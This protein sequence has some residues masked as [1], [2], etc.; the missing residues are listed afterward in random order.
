MSRHPDLESEQA[1]IDRAYEYLEQARL[2][3]VNLRSMVEVGRGGTTQARY[4]RDVIEE[5][6]LNRL[7]RLQLGSASLIFGRIDTESGERFHIGRLAVADEHQE[8]VVVD[9]RAPVAEAFY[10]ATGRD[11]MG[12]VLRRHFVSR[13]RELIDIEDELF[14]LD[15]LDETYQ[16]HG[17]L[18]AALEQNRD[19]QLRDIVATIQ[20]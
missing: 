11:P 7:S 3:A 16:G 12:L 15:R 1:Y 9:W 10:R 17:A 8:P 18:V 4:E 5:Q 19:G 20:G 6:I 13:G 14:D 2:R